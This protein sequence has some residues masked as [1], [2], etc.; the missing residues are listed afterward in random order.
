[1]PDDVSVKENWLRFP[2][3]FRQNTIEYL[4][5]KSQSGVISVELLLKVCV[6][7]VSLK[8]RGVEP[9]I[10]MTLKVSKLKMS[11]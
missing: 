7:N 8:S 9:L 4:Y 3:V 1:M 2:L 6:Q 11:F 10:E 5:A